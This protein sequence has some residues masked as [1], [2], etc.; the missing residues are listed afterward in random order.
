MANSPILFGPNNTAQNLQNQILQA[1]GSLLASNGAKNYITYNNFENGLTTGWSLGTV[2]T[3]T[4]GI[5]TGTPTFG[6]G[7]SA[8]LSITT[9]SSGQIAGNYSLS[10][11]SSAA[12][13]QGNM[14]ASDALT[15]DTSDQAKV[16]TAQFY[17]KAAS[18]SSNANFS[19]TSSNSF[20]VACY[21]VTN[22]S[23]LP[24]AGN[25][26]MTQGSG[27][28][29]AT[30]TFQT[31]LTTA[32][33]R[34]VVYNVNA[35]S[36]AVTLYFDRFY[37][38]PQ[39]API[40]PVT[41]DW[42]SFT[43]TGSWT[44]NTTYTGYMRRVG[45]TQE[46]QVL[47]SLSGAPTATG[48]T[49]NAPSSVDYSKL[50]G[51]QVYDESYLGSGYIIHSATSYMVGYVQATPTANVF[52]V[53]YDN[54]S[55]SNVIT[56]PITQTAPVTFGSGDLLT[57][58]FSYPIA[59][60]SS[61]VQM[62]NDTDTRL[63][64]FGGT[65]NQTINNT[66]PS[67]TLTVTEDTHGAYSGSTYTVPVT[68]RYRIGGYIR[69]S[70]VA[71]TAGNAIEVYYAV[72]GGGNQVIGRVNPPAYTGT[73]QAMISYEENFNAGDTVV[74]KAY[75]DV[76]MTGAGTITFSRLSGPS[77]IAATESVNASY[78]TTAGQSI[79]NAT[80]TIINFD[81]KSFDSHNAVTA[82]SN[83]KF[84]APVSGKYRVSAMIA[85]S[86]STTNTWNYSAAIYKNGV[87]YRA[88][89]DKL[90]N[91]NGEININTGSTL[92]QLNAGDYISLYF[93]QNIGTAKALAT[94]TGYNYIDIERVGN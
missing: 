84:T 39:T 30:C 70:S 16:L 79:P 46:V 45:D 34:F 15:I 44:T 23:W 53:T 56:N 60:A 11:V 55:G 93:S 90:G 71:W 8:N 7:A 1:N 5:P 72:N 91:L 18:G 26:S 92:I 86:S 87:L 2:G 75:S 76:S 36:G 25:F 50:T 81:T 9:V 28:G 4:N 31:N 33:I 58:R 27:V 32:S 48:L 88:L 52:R 17:Y 61:N 59:G 3:L 94:T 22:S 54:V 66:T 47:I 6:S 69:S 20:G 49:L 80:P 21:D 85:L 73:A 13:T 74:F 78:G 38:G 42:Q 77:V 83:W 14:L 12:T 19:G 65:A 40:G 51:G 35:T 67:L 10:L 63:V 89:D 43:P 64:S 68:G 62:S 37:L 57:F 82:G 41:T 24:V 29:I